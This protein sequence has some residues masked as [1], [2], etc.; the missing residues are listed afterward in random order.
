MQTFHISSAEKA[1]LNEA[2]VAI[3]KANTATAEQ[4][5][6]ENAQLAYKALRQLIRGR[7]D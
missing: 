3:Y 7:L 4:P 6:I 2:C 5:F 1:Q